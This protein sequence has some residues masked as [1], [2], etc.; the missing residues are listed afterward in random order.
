MGVNNMSEP[1]SSVYIHMMKDSLVRKESILRI[2]FELTEKQRDLLSQD[3][4]DVEQFSQLLEEKGE[5]IDEINR[6]DDGF[7]GIFHKI[8]KVL[9]TDRQQYKSEI[10]QMKKLVSSITEYSARIQSLEKLNH[11]RFA[12]Y[13]NKQ[14]RVVRQANLNQRT[15]S[16]YSQNMVGR[17]QS[18]S[19]YYFNETK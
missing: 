6:L 1:D 5:R 19:S 16:T 18:G 12:S 17:S 7:D 9:M 8:E 2:L 13:L 10:E 15:V 14:K 11:D 4:L 3:E